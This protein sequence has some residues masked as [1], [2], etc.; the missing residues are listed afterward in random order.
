MVFVGHSGKANSA[1]GDRRLGVLSFFLRFC[2][3]ARRYRF[4][5]RDSLFERGRDP[6]GG[7]ESR[8]L[9]KARG[10]VVLFA[11]AAREGGGDAR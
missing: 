8:D 2:V 10:S 3:I 6:L 5:K 7:V 9:E 11:R 1:T 4:G